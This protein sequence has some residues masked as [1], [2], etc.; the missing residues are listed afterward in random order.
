MLCHDFRSGLC[1][2]VSAALRRNNPQPVLGVVKT[3]DST[4][5]E[6]LLKLINTQ[7]CLTNDVSTSSI[8]F[9]L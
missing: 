5:Y 6:C 3:R 2:R 9:F 1:A 4:G 7:Y 8:L